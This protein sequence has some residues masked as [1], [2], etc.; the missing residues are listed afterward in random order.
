MVTKVD[1]AVLVGLEGYID[2]IASLGLCQ[3]DEQG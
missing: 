3:E 2:I 1:I